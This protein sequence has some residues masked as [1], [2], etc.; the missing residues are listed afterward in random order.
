MPAIPAWRGTP[1]QIGL[2]IILTA[3]AVA[4]PLFL[5]SQIA[6]LF[7]P[8]VSLTAHFAADRELDAYRTD[9][10]IA[11]VPV[12]KVTSV[13][14]DSD[15]GAAVTVKISED[16]YNALGTAPA[17]AIRPTTLL[18]GRYYVD[19][20]P[21]GLPGTPDG[22]IPPPR[23]RLPVE[24]EQVAAALQP[25][26]RIG[27][28]HAVAALDDTLTSGGDTALRQLLAHAP[29]TLPP[30][31]GVLAG[32]RGEHPDSDLPDLVGNL[33]S[34]ARVLTDRQGQLVG[35]VTDLATTSGVL[36]RRAP[37]VAAA[38]DTLPSTLDSANT[39]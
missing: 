13:G 3:A 14:P 6:T 27:G 19:L 37:D 34:T 11:G 25:S 30:V 12:G 2:T 7:T 4:I 15:G 20:V 9:A 26:A 10:K 5:K 32:L 36:D 24:V 23:T 16:A 21:G 31:G 28:Q 8:G 1:F 33:E 38:L 39:G 18:G 22:D 35:T 29:S 17:A